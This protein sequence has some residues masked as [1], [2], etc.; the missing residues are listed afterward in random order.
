MKL[1]RKKDE[2]DYIKYVEALSLLSD[3]RLIEL[4]EIAGEGHVNTFPVEW[5]NA[6]SVVMLRRGLLGS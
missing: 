6:L 4:R 5:R 1:S 3:F 2:G